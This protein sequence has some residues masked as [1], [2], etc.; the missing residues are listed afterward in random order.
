MFGEK[1]MA[2][3][4]WSYG[5]PQPYT[6]KCTSYCVFPNSFKLKVGISLMAVGRN[7]MK[8]CHEEGIQEPL[9]T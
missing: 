2:A 8:W 6:Y 3:A 9:I 1:K 7:K 4:D 5:L